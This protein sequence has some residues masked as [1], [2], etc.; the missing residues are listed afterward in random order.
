MTF[1]RM[2][3]L[4]QVVPL[5]TR[6][7]RAWSVALEVEGFAWVHQWEGFAANA[8]D[9]TNAARG[10]FYGLLDS[11]EMRARYP[12]RVRSCLQQPREAH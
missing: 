10:D 7:R 11:P 4:G 12:L 8:E 1:L 9:A 5:E 6:Q 3:K 2:Q